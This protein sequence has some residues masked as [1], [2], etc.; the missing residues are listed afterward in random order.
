MNIL[1]FVASMIMVM[2]M[3]TYG[4]I[5][6]YRSFSLIQAQFKDHIDHTERA[7]INKIAD[8]LY[9]NSKGETVSKPSVPQGK[10]PEGKP[11]INFSVFVDKTKRANLTQDYPKIHLMTKK[12][13]YN[14]F[15]DQPFFKRIEQKRPDIVDAFLASLLPAIESLPPKKRPKKPQDL[16][17]LNLGD[18]ELNRFS[19]EIFNETHKRP[20]KI[21]PKKSPKNSLTEDDKGEN[22]DS[23]YMEY[24]AE[25]YKTPPGTFSFLSYINFGKSGKVR[26]YLASKEVLKS[27]FDDPAVVKA[28]VDARQDLYKKVKSKEMNPDQ[29]SEL[30]KKQF[31]SLADPN[32][33]ESVLDFTVTKTNPKRYN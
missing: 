12:L 21:K 8:D 15:K 2:A 16:S 4:R 3:L 29:A 9:E 5:E 26:V 11:T 33:G 14:L 30:F 13:I 28:I 10:K 23:E 22:D 17:N 27:I 20:E 18:E 7:F 1:L 6:T 25:H 19:Y 32:L 24:N 31:S